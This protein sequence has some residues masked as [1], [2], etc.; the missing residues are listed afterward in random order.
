MEVLE[1]VPV[2]MDVEQAVAPAVTR[3]SDRALETQL[4]MFQ[5]LVVSTRQKR[6]M[7][8]EEAAVEGG[9]DAAVCG[10]AEVAWD[11]VKR[12][13]FG[14]AF[15][16]LDGVDSPEQLRQLAEEISKMN[17]TLLVICGNEGEA[18]EEIWAR[19]LGAWLYLPGVSAGS[20]LITLCEQAQP[21][22][23]KLTGSFVLK[24]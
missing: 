6:R 18:L 23:E 9:W 7:M 8:L 15:V 10:D 12:R 3:V 11:A 4:D 5:C 1:T 2:G 16:D 17:N 13:R 14:L 22:V 20:D 21:I 19:Q 24:A